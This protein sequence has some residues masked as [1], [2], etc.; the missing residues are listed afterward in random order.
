MAKGSPKG[1]E[2]E[3]LAKLLADLAQTSMAEATALESELVTCGVKP[4]F[5]SA[6]VK[7]DHPRPGRVVVQCRFFG[8]PKG[9][10]EGSACRFAHVARK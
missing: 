9:C 4:S 1:V 7:G 5:S 6:E 8:T 10:R 2:G 3:C